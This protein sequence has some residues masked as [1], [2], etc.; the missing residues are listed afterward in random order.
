M[1]DHLAISRGP[2]TGPLNPLKTDV[3]RGPQGLSGRP[4]PLGPHRNSTTVFNKCS[5]SSFSSFEFWFLSAVTATVH[6][7]CWFR[8]VLRRIRPYQRQLSVWSVCQL[9]VTLSGEDLSLNMC[10]GGGGQ[11]QSDQ[12]PVETSPQLRAD[13]HF[14]VLG[15][16]STVPVPD[17]L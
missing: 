2:F 11:G 16:F 15:F 12:S 10:G 9:L 8:C 4:G 1:G 17:S 13:I 7:R 5:C 3:S 6:F 14:T